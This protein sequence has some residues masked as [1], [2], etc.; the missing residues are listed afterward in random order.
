MVVYYRASIRGVR[1][2]RSRRGRPDVLCEGVD[3][4]A[5]ERAASVGCVSEGAYP[6]W[7]VR[8][9]VDGPCGVLWPSGTALMLHGRGLRYFTKHRHI[10]QWQQ[11]TA[12]ASFLTR[13]HAKLHRRVAEK[14]VATS[15]AIGVVPF[16]TADW[17][18]PGV[19]DAS[20][21]TRVRPVCACVW[22]SC[23]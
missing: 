5:A 12:N 13:T 18:L 9:P 21:W 3:L 4:L 23:S 2:V 1:H 14:L 10:S 15:V 8:M 19:F 6:E 20:T 16:L 7:Q 17:W 11:L 22:H